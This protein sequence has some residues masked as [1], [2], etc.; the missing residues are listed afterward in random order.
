M[1]SDRKSPTDAARV[2]AKEDNAVE[3]PG[4]G[5]LFV[6]YLSVFIDMLGLSLIIPIIPFLALRFG[7][8]STAL[9]YI[10]ASYNG[11]QMI[12]VPI[13]GYL[14]DKYGRKPM[15]LA[16]LFGS[17]IGFLIQ[18]LAQDILT[19]CLGRALT[20]LFGGSVPIVNAYICD[21]VPA[22][23]RPKYFAQ[24]G[25]VIIVAFMFGP[26]IGAGLAQFSLETPMFVACGTA[27]FGFLLALVAFKEPKRKI[28]NKEESPR[29]PPQPEGEDSKQGLDVVGHAP[30]ETSTTFAGEEE[31]VEISKPEY[32]MPVRL[33]YVIVFLYSLAFSG[34]IY[35]VGLLVFDLYGWE[36]LEYGFLAMGASIWT[37]LNQMSSFVM[38]QK[39]FGKH[40]SLMVGSVSMAVAY[41]CISFWG[42]D[43]KAFTGVT[44]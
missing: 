5:S 9:G 38:F 19:F 42:D 44:S 20:G 7:A 16:S 6:A 36:S 11:A 30:T 26:G 17:F 25:A 35:Y 3:A 1:D 18:G 22:P 39:K 29:S 31:E 14:S 32:K 40:A 43:I 33:M 24:L 15:I 21:T 4:K 41:L 8:D 10:Y 23:N 27:G 34:Y 37:V 13:T 28:P 2:V 12:S